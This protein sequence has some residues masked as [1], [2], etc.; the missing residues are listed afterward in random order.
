VK[1]LTLQEPHGVTF[2]KTAFFV[3][4]TMKTPDL[5]M[6]E[7]FKKLDKV[8]DCLLRN[9]QCYSEKFRQVSQEEHELWL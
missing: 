2:Q 8:T 7:K 6:L 4:T 9:E 3:V 5:K 1:F